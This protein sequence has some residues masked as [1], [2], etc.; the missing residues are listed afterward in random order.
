MSFM[1]RLSDEAG[2]EDVMPPKVPAVLECQRPGRGRASIATTVQA[3]DDEPVVV[4]RLQARPTRGRSS[5]PTNVRGRAAPRSIEEPSS[6][7][8]LPQ[9]VPP[10]KSKRLPPLPC[11]VSAPKPKL[12][13]TRDLA[14]A[15]MS[16]NVCWT[17]GDW[18][19]EQRAELSNPVVM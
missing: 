4:P 5:S 9:Q 16:D 8:K 3:D 7:P 1:S 15:F 11:G 17:C 13:H 19:E 6:L 10:A 12:F 14:D 18:I 2:Q